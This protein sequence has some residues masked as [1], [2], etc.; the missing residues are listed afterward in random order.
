MKRAPSAKRKGPEQSGPFLG[1]AF[2]ER[3]V[4]PLGEVPDASSVIDATFRDG[5]RAF[6]YWLSS[7]VAVQGAAAL[8]EANAPPASDAL[9]QVR[10]IDAQ[11]LD[12]MRELDRLGTRAFRVFVEAGDKI[13]TAFETVT[14]TG[15]LRTLRAQASA[16]M[17]QA[18]KVPPANH[19][20][21]TPRALIALARSIAERMSEAGKTPTRAASSSYVIILE[22]AIAAIA[23]TWPDQRPIAKSA[24]ELARAALAGGKRT[25]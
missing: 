19:R 16:A 11:C 13:G 18:S 17:D 1:I 2:P 12:L 23:R 24:E 8:A 10:Q 25:A 20:R 5:S 9:A 14:I 6:L 21:P 4:L 3:V 7:E 22:L 15:A